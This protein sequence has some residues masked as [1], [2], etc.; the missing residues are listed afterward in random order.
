MACFMQP[1]KKD[2]NKKNFEVIKKNDHSVH[3][4]LQE[5]KPIVKN[6]WNAILPFRT[7]SCKKQNEQNLN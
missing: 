4:R 6:H 1:S 3:F 5:S 7:D 2:E